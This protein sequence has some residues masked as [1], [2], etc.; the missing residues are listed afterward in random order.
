MDYV[1]NM[2]EL[3]R[4][5]HKYAVENHCAAIAVVHADNSVT[6]SPLFDSA[7]PRLEEYDAFLTIEDYQEL[8]Q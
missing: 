3:S 4:K 1:I 5:L 6:I 8:F 2:Q 7:E